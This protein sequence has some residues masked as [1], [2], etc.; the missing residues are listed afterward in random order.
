MKTVHFFS[1]FLVLRLRL[2]IWVCLWPINKFNWN[3]NDEPWDGACPPSGRKKWTWIIQINVKSTPGPGAIKMWPVMLW[4]SGIGDQTSSRRSRRPWK[5][6]NEDA[7]TGQREERAITDSCT[8]NDYKC[9]WVYFWDEHRLEQR[10]FSRACHLEIYNKEADS[11]VAVSSG[12]TIWWRFPVLISNVWSQHRCRSLNPISAQLRSSSVLLFVCLTLFVCMF[13]C[14]PAG[15]L[16]PFLTAVAAT[17]C[18]PPLQPSPGPFSFSP[19]PSFSYKL[20][21]PPPPLLL[22]I[23]CPFLCLS[24]LFRLFVLKV[25]LCLYSAVQFAKAS[26]GH[27]SLWPQEQFYLRKDE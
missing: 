20:S 25:G 16:R 21:P 22:F 10:E 26:Q 17:C 11:R 14:L 13:I 12:E 2:L 27:H 24:L 15:T 3:Y 23:L 18:S 1:V 19:S 7:L 6:L 5:S 9:V 8:N 4:V